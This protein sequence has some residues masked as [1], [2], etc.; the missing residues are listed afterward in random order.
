MPSSL[1]RF[2]S[3]LRRVVIM[4]D[5]DSSMFTTQD[6]T[7]WL[8]KLKND[9]SIRFPVF[10]NIVGII[11]ATLSHLLSIMSSNLGVTKKKLRLISMKNEFSF[12]TMAVQGL[13]KH[14]FASINYQEGNVYSKLSIEKKGVHL[15]NS[16]SPVEIIQHAEDIM[17]RLYNI[18]DHDKRIKLYDILKEIADVERE[19]FEKVDLGD[20]EYYRSKQI[21]DEEAYKKDGESSPYAHYTFWNETFGKFYGETQPPPYGAFDVKLA[22][23][24]KTQMKA[25]LD[26]F[27]NQE[28]ANLIRQ[29]M[30]R[31]N[32]EII[33]TIN[34]PY[35]IFI[36]RSIPEEIIPWVAKRDLV[37]NICMPYYI[38]LG[39]V[40]IAMQDNHT[41]KLISDFY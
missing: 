16:N 36:G 18:Y 10:A 27:K 1:A 6:W 9:E 32:K 35:E 26:S 39:A 30:Q 7:N 19:I 4:S 34:I 40:G 23:N 31:R 38:A 15:K 25:F 21:K 2:P 22:I 14:Y 20:V 3:S 41:T 37:A 24:N 17:K 28:L 12:D 13:T 33:A 11:D 8:V 29:N 5:T